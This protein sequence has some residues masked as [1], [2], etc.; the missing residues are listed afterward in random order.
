MPVLGGQIDDL[1]PRL[2]LT[3]EYL[4]QF[5]REDFHTVGFFTVCAPR[6]LTSIILMLQRLD[7]LHFRFSSLNNVDSGVK[8][9][10]WLRQEKWFS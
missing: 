10:Y 7:W 9:L 6:T 4:G 8:A 5:L 2:R 3:N 1:G